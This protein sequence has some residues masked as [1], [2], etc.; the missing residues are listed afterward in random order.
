VRCRSVP[1]PS[2]GR[3]RAGRR[4]LDE[5]LLAAAREGAL[6]ALAEQ[7]QTAPGSPW[8][9]VRSAAEYLDTTEEVHEWCLGPCAGPSTPWP[10]TAEPSETRLT[11]GCPV[12]ENLG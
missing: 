11:H 9:V 4:R 7:G 10:L 6:Q 1:G 3:D 8:L 5:V 2:H 12:R